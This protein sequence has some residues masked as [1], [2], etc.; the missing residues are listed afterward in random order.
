MYFL[1]GLG[2]DNAVAFARH[3]AARHVGNT[4]DLGALDARIA[5]GGE[6]IGRLARLGHGNDE[7]RR[8][9]DG[10][11]IAELAS[12]LNLGRNASPALNKVLGDEAG[13]IAGAAGR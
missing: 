7:S 9:D 8:R 10:V 6:G 12:R 1:V 3:R 11:A 4:K 2:V 5:N 13:V